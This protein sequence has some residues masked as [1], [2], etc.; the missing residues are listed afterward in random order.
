MAQLKVS[1]YVTGDSPSADEMNQLI[2]E[3]DGNM[4][5]IDETTKNYVSATYDL[6]SATYKWRNAYFSGDVTLDTITPYETGT[7]KDIVID[8]ANYGYLSLDSGGL[9]INGSRDTLSS[10]FSDWGGA[11]SA[12]PFFCITSFLSSV[13]DYYNR[14]VA[15][16]HDHG[17]DI[18]TSSYDFASEYTLFNERTTRSGQT[19]FN[20]INVYS[21]GGASKDDEASCFTFKAHNLNTTDAYADDYSPYKFISYK[22]NDSGTISSLG[23][24]DLMMIFSNNNTSKAYLYGDGSFQTKG[25]LYFTQ[26]ASPN[27]INVTGSGTEYLTTLYTAGSAQNNYLKLYDALANYSYNLNYGPIR[28][29]YGS[30]SDAIPEYTIDTDGIIT[31]SNGSSVVA[32]SPNTG[33]TDNLDYIEGFERGGMLLFVFGTTGNTITIRHAQGSYPGSDSYYGVFQNKNNDDIVL[34]SSFD[35]VVYIKSGSNNFRELWRDV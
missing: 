31:V 3:R 27:L 25:A 33:T 16:T 10:Y 1:D 35:V 17:Y 21:T 11:S 14:V 8:Y 32:A 23:G 7:Y 13:A 9:V 22:H 4:L 15:Y 34:D 6:G 19:Y 2:A 24:D 18:T 20:G 12:L 5:P 29:F 28:G 26:N 30:G